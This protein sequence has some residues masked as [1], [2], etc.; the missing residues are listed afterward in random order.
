MKKRNYLNKLT[1]QFFPI[2][3]VAE[4]KKT[5]QNLDPIFTKFLKKA[6]KYGLF[7]YGGKKAIDLVSTTIKK[8]MEKDKK[9]KEEL[10]KVEVPAEVERDST[11]GSY[12]L[13][14]AHDKTLHH[15]IGLW[16]P[17]G[18][19]ALVFGPKGAMKSYL[20]AGTMIQVANNEYPSILPP[21][22]RTYVRP[23]N[24]ISIYADGE[25][26][27][28]I[29]GNRYRNVASKLDD[30]FT[31]VEAKSF[32]DDTNKFFAKVEEIAMEHPSGT[33]IMLGID[34][35]KSLV[36]NRSP[37]EAKAYL[38]AI[39]N[40]RS[41]LEEKGIS[42]TTITINHTT[43]DGENMGGSYDLTCL[44]PYVF[45]INKSHILTV[46]ESR[47]GIKGAQYQL[48]V[49]DKDYTYLENEG[50]VESSLKATPEW[51]G[52]MS[53]EKTKKMVEEY[54]VGVAGHGFNALAKKYGFNS[55]EEVKREIDKY[56]RYINDD[57]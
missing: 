10:K 27:R 9:S 24:V 7:F 42:L 3:I 54:Q 6:T 41:R 34:N 40:L 22:E 4:G 20:V 45:K 13:S 32:S 18:Y 23:V 5:I 1:L 52:K 12:K 55:G 51:K 31:V 39:K 48:K 14:E 49:V 36:N 43:K 35:V 15:L 2:K 8:K 44:T 28:T 21:D 29:L 16:I 47:T 46:E 17:E 25:N 26:G 11:F 33:K 30:C 53:L 37:K 19:D 50:N 57:E 38:N 56:H